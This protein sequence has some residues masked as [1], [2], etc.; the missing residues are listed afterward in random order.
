MAANKPAEIPNAF[1]AKVKADLDRNKQL[2]VIER[3][4]PNTP[5]T[6]YVKM[7]VVAKNNGKP[8]RVVDFEALN[9]ICLRRTYHTLAPFRIACSIPNDQLLTT[10]KAWN[11]YHSVAVHP[12]DVHYFTFITEWGRDR[13]KSVQQGWIASSDA[14]TQV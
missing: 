4:P 9:K 11:S 12:D 13:Y 5:Q 14:Y 1:E 2:G 6:F 3:V 7:L 8:R 10:A